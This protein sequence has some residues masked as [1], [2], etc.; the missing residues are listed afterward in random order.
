MSA[1]L[2]SALALAAS[3]LTVKD[4][5]GTAGAFTVSALSIEP[6]SPAPGEN[7][8]LSYQY[9]VPQGLVVIGGTSEYSATYNFIPLSPT[10]EPLCMN[11]PCPLSTGTYANHTTSTWPTGLSGT[12]TTQ[13]KWR[14]DNSLLLLC[15]S[16][17]GK[18][19]PTS[20]L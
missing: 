12:L 8:T 15:I 6:P 10:T 19:Q 7:I 13:I 1:L 16:I 18:V 4:C 3:A 9:I 14:S 20:W 11:I 17:S 5:A 2:L